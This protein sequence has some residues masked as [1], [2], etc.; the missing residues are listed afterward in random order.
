[1]PYSNIFCVKSQ[2]LLR[3]AFFSPQKVKTDSRN[4]RGNPFLP[5]K[6]FPQY[7][8]E[9]TVKFH[10]AHGLYRNYV[11]SEQP[12]VSFVPDRAAF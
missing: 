5:V 1:M 7:H 6:N 3:A 4:T 8:A 2:P 9:E 10:S 12:A 11:S